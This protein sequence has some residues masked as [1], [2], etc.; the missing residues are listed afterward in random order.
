MNETRIEQTTAAS[1]ARRIRASTRTFLVRDVRPEILLQ[2]R[3]LV[4]VDAH[5][6]VPRALRQ[7]LHQTRLPAG[8]G[9]LE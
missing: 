7:I 3:V 9:T 1:P 5:E 4:I 6:P 8:R 2:I